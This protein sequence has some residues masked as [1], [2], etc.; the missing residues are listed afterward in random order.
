MS[1]R[2]F[3]FGFFYESMLKKTHQELVI[4]KQKLGTLNSYFKDIV[5]ADVYIARCITEKALLE[6]EEPNSQFS[7]KVHEEINRD[8]SR[9]ASALKNESAEPELQLYKVLQNLDQYLTLA[10][11]NQL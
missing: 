2:N 11:N 3:E 6:K 10:N 5:Y 7:F 1:T 4:L 9:F 8:I